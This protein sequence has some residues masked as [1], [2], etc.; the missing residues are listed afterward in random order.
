MPGLGFSSWVIGH[1]GY[2]WDH[3]CKVIER[4][5]GAWA[6][7]IGISAIFLPIKLMLLELSQVYLHLMMECYWAHSILWLGRSENTQ[8]VMSNPGHMV[9]CGPMVK[10]SVPSKHCSEPKNC[11]KKKKKKVKC[12]GPYSFSPKFWG[13]YNDAPINACEI[14]HASFIFVTNSPRPSNLNCFVAQES[15]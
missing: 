4:G 5:Y 2:P 12:K 1:K 6:Q 11:L 8:F 7:A 14:I 9:T 13:L 3:R 15:E 10:H